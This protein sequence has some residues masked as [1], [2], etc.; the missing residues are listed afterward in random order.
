[1]RKSQVKKGKKR[2]KA[3][4]KAA[5]AEE[6]R[7]SAIDTDEWVFIFDDIGA[8][9]AEFQEGTKELDTPF[10]GHPTTNYIIHKF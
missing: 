1:M 5:A 10:K 7:D 4:E 6:A 3:K 9:D 2:A 8:E